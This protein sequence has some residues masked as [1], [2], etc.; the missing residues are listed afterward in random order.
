MTRIGDVTATL[1]LALTGTDEMMAAGLH[2]PGEAAAAAVVAGGG[3][4]GGGGVIVADVV[5]DEVNATA[6]GF[7]AAS[8]TAV[9]TVTV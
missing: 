5:N 7:P 6:M 2:L 3:G 8:V 9:L 1:V 4:G